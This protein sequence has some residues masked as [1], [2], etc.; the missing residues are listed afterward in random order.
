MSI[1]PDIYFEP[2]WGELF[3]EKDDG[4][5]EIFEY[6]NENGK[7]YYQFVK[8]RIDLKLNGVEY[9]DTITPFGY[10]GPI[11]LN[12]KEG[13]REELIRDFDIEFSK[14]CSQNN[15]ITEFV[16]FSPWLRNHIDFEGIYDL[17]NNHCTYGI[18]LTVNDVFYDEFS[19]SARCKIRKSIKNNVVIE[20]D[21]TGNSIK[22]FCRLYNLTIDKNGIKDFYIYSEKYFNHIFKSLGKNIFLI[23]AKLQDE[24]ISSSILINY[25]DYL[26][27]LFLGNDPKYLSL[28]VNSHIIYEA[29]KFGKEN[30]KKYFH[31]GSGSVS[32]SKFKESFTKKGIFDI[33]L[34]NKIRNEK[35]YKE[36]CTAN[37]KD[38][39][40]F[41]PIY[42]A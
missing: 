4:K 5:A 10:N 26:H 28:G 32:L 1:L 19:Q 42:R 8:R 18:D 3:S 36:M 9:F 38:N 31:L 34:G 40:D 17:K 39:A 25:G 15:I 35:V 7:I 16:R 29:C 2:T 24:Y 21:F 23:N 11:V 37:Q 33:Y 14:Y 20:Y 27:G 12:T 41:F 6:E 30:G 13:K 22:E